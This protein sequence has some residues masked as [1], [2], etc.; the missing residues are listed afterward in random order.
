MGKSNELKKFSM[1]I[2][3]DNFA[4]DKH[5]SRLPSIFR[6]HSD[7]EYHWTVECLIVLFYNMEPKYRNKQFGHMKFQ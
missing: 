7:T 3:E 5:H 6:L 2:Y 1:N 4:H